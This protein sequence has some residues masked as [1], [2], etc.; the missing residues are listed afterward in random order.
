MEN[1]YD[2]IILANGLFP[3]KEELLS[4]LKNAS[5]LVCCDGAS[6]KLYEF[7]KEPNYVIGDMDSISSN[8]KEL[9]NHILINKPDQNINDLSKAIEFCIEKNHKRIAILGGGGLREDHALANIS[10]LHKHLPM[11]E[12]IVMISDFGIFTPICSSKV[13]K[14]IKGE[15]VSIFSLTPDTIIS[16]IG[17]KYKICSSKLTSWWEGDRKSTR[18]N[19]SH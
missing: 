14:S 13:F 16:T 18:L 15:Q 9:W 4:L 19:S 8:L 5:R 11:L 7:G 17:L 12:Q 6:T 10:L 1:N 2:A 3:Q